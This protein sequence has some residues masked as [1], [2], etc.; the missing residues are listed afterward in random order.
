MSRQVELADA[1][2]NGHGR[3][4]SVVL[5]EGAF[6]PTSNPNFLD[7]GSGASEPLP[8]VRGKRE[9]PALSAC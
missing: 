3:G 4:A 9:A 1:C 5:A 2:W 8:I 6:A 7:A